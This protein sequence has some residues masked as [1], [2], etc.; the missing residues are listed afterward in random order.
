[1]AYLADHS[2]VL[3]QAQRRVWGRMAKIAWYR[4]GGLKGET[5]FAIHLRHRRSKGLAIV[6]A[7][8]PDG[9]CRATHDL[10]HVRLSDRLLGS[11]LLV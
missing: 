9:G 7:E 2:D 11:Y 3:T 10:I 1:M 6:T 4:G 8:R 5:A